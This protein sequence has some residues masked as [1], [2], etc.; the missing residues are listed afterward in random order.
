MTINA[1]TNGFALDPAVATNDPS[2]SSDAT[3]QEVSELLL[4][5]EIVRKLSGKV[6]KQEEHLAAA[7]IALAEAEATLTS[8]ENPNGME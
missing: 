8:L 4:A 6:A 1:E 7:R 5:R 2:I 3:P